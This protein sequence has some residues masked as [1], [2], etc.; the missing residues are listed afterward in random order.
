MRLRDA[1]VVYTHISPLLT[2]QSL[3]AQG[4]EGY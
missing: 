2:A 3:V 4:K 1:V